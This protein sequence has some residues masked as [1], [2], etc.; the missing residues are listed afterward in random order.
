[1]KIQESREFHSF[2][3]GIR[4]NISNGCIL[5]LW[6]SKFLEFLLTILNSARDLWEQ[7]NSLLFIWRDYHTP[8]SIL[9][10]HCWKG[11]SENWHWSSFERHYGKLLSTIEALSHWLERMTCDS[12]FEILRCCR[13]IFISRKSGKRE[14]EYPIIMTHSDCPIST[15]RNGP[16]RTHWLTKSWE[17]DHRYRINIFVC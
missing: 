16:D 15:G 7:N 13:M 17:S 6:I 10:T 14:E 2:H 5:R 12:Q 1:M 4:F 3:H 9:I 11:Q 8:V